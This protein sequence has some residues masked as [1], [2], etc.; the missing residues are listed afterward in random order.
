MKRKYKPTGCAKFFLFLVI[1]VPI[2]SLGAHLI[3]GKDWRTTIN[4]ITGGE[5]TERV[6]TNTKNVASDTKAFNDEIDNL[7]LIIKN[8][9]REIKQLKEKAA[10]V[11]WIE[12]IPF[13]NVNG[14]SLSYSSYG[15]ISLRFPYRILRWN[16]WDARALDLWKRII[17]AIDLT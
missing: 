13:M 8:Q 12:I 6:Q 3:Q 11:W 4:D 1:F 15:L 7:K 5:T 2:A 9:E 17:L 14:I 10:G 16:C